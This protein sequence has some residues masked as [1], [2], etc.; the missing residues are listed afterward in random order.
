MNPY[1][2][3]EQFARGERMGAQVERGRIMGEFERVIER[4]VANTVSTG[5][6]HGA[7]GDPTAVVADQ[8]ARRAAPWRTVLDEVASVTLTPAHA[9]PWCPTL[10]APPAGGVQAGG[11]KTE[12]PSGVITVAGADVLPALVGLTCNVSYQ[13]WRAGEQA[14]TNL[15]TE[16]ALKATALWVVAQLTAGVTASA[17]LA[18]AVASIEAAGWPPTHVIGPTSKLLAL[19]VQ[20][21]GLAGLTVVPAAT[22]GVTLVLSVPGTWVGWSPAVAN[23]VEPAIGGMAV[24]AYCW[25]VANKGPGSVATIT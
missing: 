23:A 6:P 18:A 19:D 10:T 24:T 22:G 5:L 21:L 14:I 17:D 11:E 7:A 8:A 4:V 2:P 25:A 16:S 3:A 20:R 13:A 15:M 12:L 9:R 1:D